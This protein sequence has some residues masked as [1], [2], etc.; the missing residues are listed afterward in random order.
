MQFASLPGSVVS[1]LVRALDSQ[2]IPRNGVSSL[3]R[4]VR[5]VGKAHSNGPDAFGQGRQ[6]NRSML[7]VML[8]TWQMHSYYSVS[9][10][11][12]GAVSQLAA[13]VIQRE[14]PRSEQ[15]TTVLTP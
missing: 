5:L 10:L 9:G 3:F 11:T 12:S 4:P 6:P 1:R 2:S 7:P 15:V 8:L 14:I 13:Y